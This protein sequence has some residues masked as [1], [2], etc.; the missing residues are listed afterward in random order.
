M[1]AGV[2][3]LSRRLASHCTGLKHYEDY[4]KMYYTT[5]GRKQIQCS[6][7]SKHVHTLWNI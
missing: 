2:F 4:N 5:P 1:L 3:I 6:K 7:I